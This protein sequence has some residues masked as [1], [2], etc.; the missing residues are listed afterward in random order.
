VKKL[1]YIL[2]LLLLFSC[3][4]LFGTQKDK[5]HTRLQSAEK[6]MV[7]ETGIRYELIPADTLLF[8]APQQKPNDTTS[9]VK[10]VENKQLKIEATVK[11]GCVKKVKATQKPKL[12]INPYKKI[13]QSEKKLTV[14]QDIK[15]KQS[16]FKDVY[17]LYAFL[18]IGFLIVVNNFTKRKSKT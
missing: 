12:K 10:M 1:L 18:G 9:V 3:G 5:E 17:F 15:H 16:K 6:S 13:E 8:I 4:S 14:K 7:V 11:K 2:P